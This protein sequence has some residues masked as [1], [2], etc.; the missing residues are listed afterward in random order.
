MKKEILDKYFRKG[1]CCLEASE[2]NPEIKASLNETASKRDDHF[3]DSQNL[4]GSAL[5]ALSLAITKLFSEDEAIDNLKLIEYISDAGKLIAE[6]H[7]KE[8]VARRAFILPGLQKKTKT[9]L[10]NT[11]IGPLLFG[12]KLRE[13]LKEARSLEKMGKDL[14]LQ[15][16]LKK[17]FNKSNFLNQKS[18]FGRNQETSQ[19]SK[20]RQQGRSTVS[21]RSRQSSSRQYNQ[22]RQS[23]KTST[24]Y[25]R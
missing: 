7:H 24:Y 12:E 13:K 15:A 18:S 1:I 14:K 16:P 2:L 20:A 10:E 17:P 8:L 23:N 9:L 19:A 6:L 5:S 22:N 3:C 21:Q 11:D 25:R 4:A